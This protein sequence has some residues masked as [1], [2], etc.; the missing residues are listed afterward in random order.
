ML[1]YISRHFGLLRQSNNQNNN[2]TMK[3][4]LL[5]ALA[6]LVALS[7]ITPVRAFVGDE[8]EC[9]T[10]IQEEV[11]APISVVANLTPLTE[12]IGPDTGMV[13]Y[14]RP[15]LQGDITLRHL[16]S[17]IFINLWA[18][19]G[20]DD[21]WNSGWD[22]EF[23]LTAGM[24]RP[25]NLFGLFEASLTASVSYFDNF[26]VGTWSQNDVVKASLKAD[27]TDME[28]EVGGFTA[29]PFASYSSYTIPSARTEFEGGNIFAVGFSGSLPLSERWNLSSTFSLGWDDGA[30]GAQA[31]WLFKNSSSLNFSVSEDVTLNLLSLTTFVPFGNDRRTPNLKEKVVL[32]TGVTWKF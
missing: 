19:T 21:T 22:D 24:T 32:G 2:S 3:Q 20:F 11:S 26:D 29:V 15:V 27:F 30:F 12:Y 17:G 16:N 23:D 25:V 7:T 14:D 6:A 18:S 31:G 5:A 13:F 10:A 9:T 1:Y 8:G 28:F 4:I